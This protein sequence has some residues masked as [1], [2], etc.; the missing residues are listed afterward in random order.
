MQKYNEFGHIL[1]R[2]IERCWSFKIIII[3]NNDFF[4]LNL[5]IENYEQS[6]HLIIM[7]IK[8]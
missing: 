4:F 8:Y 5:E 1:M 3:F 7:E 6:V 2:M